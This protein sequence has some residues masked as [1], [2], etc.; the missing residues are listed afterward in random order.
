MGT[1]KIRAKMEEIDVQSCYGGHPTVFS[2]RLHHGGTFT[3][4]P[5]RKYLKGKED[6]VDLLDIDKFSIHDID[7]MM[8]ELGH[9]GEQL[10][11]LY[12][13]FQRPLG[14]LDFGLFALASDDDVRHLATFVGEHK[15]I[16]V[17]TEH[18]ETKLHTYSMS[19]NPSKVRIVEIH[20]APICSKR[21]L[22]NWHENVEPDNAPPKI[23][24]PPNPVTDTP[25]LTVEPDECNINDGSNNGEDEC[26]SNDGSNINDGSNNGDDECNSNDG[27]NNTDED[28]SEDSD[29]LVDEDNVCNNTDEDESEDS[30]FLV[31]EDNVLD[32]VDVD[33]KDFHMNVDTDVEWIG[34][35]TD[36]I[37]E[38]V[39][40]EEDIE[41]VDNEC[42]VSDSESD[43]GIQSQRKKTIKAIR[44][45]HENENA[46]ISDPFYLCQTFTSA[47]EFKKRVKLHAIETR[48]ELD[49][50]KNDAN[51]VRVTCKGSI[52]TLGKI[53]TSGTSQQQ[54]N[55]SEESK[56]PWVLYISKWK[57][58]K[59]WSVKTYVN[60]HK[61]LQTR[62]VKQ[63]DY[64]Y[65]ANQILQQVEANPNVPIKALRDELQRKFKVDISK[66]KTFRARDAALKIVRGDYGSQY[67]ILRDYL[68]EVQTRN[69]DTTI[70]LDV[71]TESDPGVETRMFKRVYVCI[72][73]LKKGFAAGKRDFLGLDGAFMKGPYPGQILTAVA[74]DGNNGI[75]PVAY[76]VVEAETFDSWSWFLSNLGDDL[77]LASNS[78]F[79]FITDR[80]KGVLPAI[81][82]L[83]PCAENR[84]CLRHIHENMKLKWRG[85]QFK[86]ILWQCA[87]TCNV[88]EFHKGMEEMRKLNKDCHAWLKLIPAHHWARSHFTGRSHCDALLNNICES[89]NSRLADGRD[90]PII[91]CL[92]FIREYIM[93]KIVTVEKAIQKS[94]GP[95]TP[96][97]TK[98]LEKIKSEAEDYQT[99][100]CGNGKYQVSGPWQ[101]QCAVDVG[102]QIC[103]CKKWELTGIPC[104]HA[105]A[106]I[107]DMRKNNREVGI[108]ETFVH[109]CYW[110]STWKEM[111][112][113]K[114]DPINGKNMWV[115]SPCP[116]TLLP[117]KHRVTI[118]RPKKKRRQ[119]AFEKDDLIKG[120]TV[121]R[122][123]KS[124][125][126]TKCKNS[127]HNSR[128]CKGQKSSDG[129][130]VGGRGGRGLGKATVKGKGKGKANT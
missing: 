14:D 47:E 42:Y 95:L 121:S 77:G 12:Y 60:E 13:H 117:P 125:T 22:L 64:K 127:G 20:E 7:D 27:S 3:S 100:F 102:Q 26:H 92:E 29:F 111:Y 4:F 59:E 11:T 85:K 74:L 128:T 63:C 72:G 15:L 99:V 36:A 69:P 30:D 45:A 112:T 79:T 32:D 62:K 5:G 101:D 84:F 25:P 33:M 17:Y 18:G 104:K 58:D 120:T 41:V 31:D 38:E 130:R 118:G 98:T 87:T 82:K 96:T 6:Y 19:P 93:K 35:L 109:P 49:F 122:A 91:T 80:Q 129:G 108:P 89:L 76:A 53:G 90:A 52:P 61:C 114:I 94:T 10:S 83:F 116:T 68:L 21:L 73:A 124:V 119:S 65:L 8:E 1:W 16:D 107:W 43:E 57:N 37:N 105:I 71:E 9:I 39:S 86:D 106:A 78:N 66:M 75:Y 40:D 70:R 51:R 113:F 46:L 50:E 126:C 103:S 88:I 97:A 55:A 23:D 44:R 48:R 81:A 67:A 123:L 115:K 54:V 110:L 34:N 2:I 28:E 24:T 56:C